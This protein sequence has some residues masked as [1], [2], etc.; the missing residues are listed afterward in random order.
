[1]TRI[2]FIDRGNQIRSVDADNNWTV[3]RA[4]VSHGVKAD[5]LALKPRA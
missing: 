5:A 4:A 2:T 1:M 3:V